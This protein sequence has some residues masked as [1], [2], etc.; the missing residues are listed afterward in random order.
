RSVRL[1]ERAMLPERAFR[2]PGAC[3][4]FREAPG[5]GEHTDEVLREPA[6]ERGAAKPPAPRIGADLGDRRFLDGIRVLEFSIAWAGPFAGRFLADLGA[7]VIK[8][9]H[10]TARGAGVTGAGGFRAKEDLA[11]WEWGRLPGPVFRS[12]IYPDADPGERPWNR[13]GVYNKMNRN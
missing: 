5:A 3:A 6:R 2:V 7:E 12:G 1:G 9:E 4:P 11:G 8:V 10:P 13:Q